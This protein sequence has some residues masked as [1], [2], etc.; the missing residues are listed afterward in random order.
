MSIIKSVVV[1][2]WVVKYLIVW[3]EGIQKS[4]AYTII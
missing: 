1:Y 4:N 2:K 3:N